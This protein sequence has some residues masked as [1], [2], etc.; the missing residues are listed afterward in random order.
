MN[1][2]NF[3]QEDKNNLIA[4][5]L[6]LGYRIIGF[7]H[8]KLNAVLKSNGKTSTLHWNPLI[9]NFDSFNLI[10]T[11]GLSIIYYEKY[12]EI[13]KGDHNGSIIK[14]SEYYLGRELQEATRFAV[15]NLALKLVK[16]KEKK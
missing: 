10:C 9:S 12:V 14:H 3:L 2:Y 4:V 7:Q 8:N 13:Y 5:A 11:L 1:N 6:M 15:F 16:I